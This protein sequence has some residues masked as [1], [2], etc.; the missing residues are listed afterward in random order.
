MEKFTSRILTQEEIDHDQLEYAK[1][2]SE[3]NE[4]L[5]QL[6]LWCWQN[7]IATNG[8]CSGHGDAGYISFAFKE[9]DFDLFLYFYDCFRTKVGYDM[10]FTKNHF[11]IYLK[12]TDEQTSFKEILEL[13]KSFTTKPNH[14]LE[15][16]LNIFLFNSKYCNYLKIYP[17][18]NTLFVSWQKFFDLNQNCG[19]EIVKSFE[20][21]NNL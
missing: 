1:K 11:E 10:Y 12:G 15:G 16:L 3:G 4:D 21:I 18:K 13:L 7:K 6:L 8:C 5:K 9:H 19:E 14:E 2:F 17:Y 20:T